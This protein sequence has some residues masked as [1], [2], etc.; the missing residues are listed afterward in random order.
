ME[1]G[2][3]MTSQR[4]FR[5][6]I[7]QDSHRFVKKGYSKPCILGGV[8]FEETPGLEANSDGDVVFHAICNAI[9]SITSVP[10]LGGIADELFNKD[11]ITDSAIYLKKA[12]ETLKKTKI[13]HVAISIEARRPRF[14]EK[15]EEM[16]EKIAEILSLSKEHV[17]ITATSG[18]GLTEFGC[19][20]G[21][22][23]FCC[24]TVYD[25]I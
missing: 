24:I 23:C 6:G 5:A 18:E 3:K 22:L 19:G 25:E 15:R 11:G 14:F 20:E 7:G 21:I 4:F 1:K 9:T 13:A 2:E 8:V 12:K 10:I 17:G 16:Q